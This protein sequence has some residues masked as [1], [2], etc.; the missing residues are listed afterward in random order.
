MRPPAQSYL[1]EQRH[2]ELVA[3]GLQPSH[4][5]GYA[6]GFFPS[7]HHVQHHHPSPYDGGRGRDCCCFRAGRFVL[8]T[9]LSILCII[10]TIVFFVLLGASAQEGHVVR[11]SEFGHHIHASSLRNYMPPRPEPQG[12]HWDGGRP[13]N[14]HA[15]FS[16]FAESYDD[17]ESYDSYDSY[18]RRATLPIPLQIRKFRQTTPN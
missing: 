2:V 6:P 4:H 9:F 11:P 7:P 16:R 15:S 13:H 10:S 3:P 8:A 12:F 14:Q 1:D 5:P 18:V 17:N